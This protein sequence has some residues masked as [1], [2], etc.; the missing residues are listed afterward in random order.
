MNYL[1]T[2][3]FCALLINF[4]LIIS[5][6]ITPL[7]RKGFFVLIGTFFVLGLALVIL[8]IKQK[9]KGKLGFFLILTGTSAA[10]FVASSVLHNLL[11]ALLGFEEPVFFLIAV[12]VCPVAF[13]VG[14][15]GSVVL[16]VRNRG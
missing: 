13:I 3:L 10:S 16:L 11:Y 9:V 7:L 5:L 2:T 15:V 12:V 14:A 4:S 6:F 1:L 8:T